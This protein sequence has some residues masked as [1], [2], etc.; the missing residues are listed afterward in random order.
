MTL[1]VLFPRFTF[2]ALMT[3]LSMLSKMCL[4]IMPISDF[5]GLIGLQDGLLVKS[6]LLTRPCLLRFQFKG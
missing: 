5:E 6:M 1:G 4:L 2:V 3:S